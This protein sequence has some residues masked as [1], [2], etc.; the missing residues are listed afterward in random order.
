MSVSTGIETTTL[1][2]LLRKRMNGIQGKELIKGA[3]AA[4]LGTLGMS[5]GIIFWLQ[6]TRQYPAALVTLAGVAVGGIIY[7]LVLVLLRI[8]ELKSLGKYVQR[9]FPR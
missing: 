9:F 5:A 6:I 7:G 1:F 2:L 8:P 3:G 4:I